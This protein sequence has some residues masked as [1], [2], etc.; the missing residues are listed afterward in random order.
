MEAVRLYRLAADQGDTKAQNNFGVMYVKGE[1]VAKDEAEAVGLYRLAADEGLADSQGNFGRLSC[2]VMA[3]GGPKEATEL[4]R[5]ASIARAL[6]M[7][8]SRQTWWIEL[9]STVLCELVARAY[10]IKDGADLLQCPCASGPRQSRHG[11]ERTSHAPRKHVVQHAAA[12]TAAPEHAAA[13]TAD[14]RNEAATTDAG[15]HV[16][17]RKEPTQEEASASDT[18]AVREEV[19]QGP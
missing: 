1:G 8:V 14:G 12:E 5:P 10:G 18:K 13:K 17:A 6:H 9:L 16:A 19:K 11:K 7:V 2:K 3:K 15:K 4:V